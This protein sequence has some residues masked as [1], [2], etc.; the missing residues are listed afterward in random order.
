MPLPASQPYGLLAEFTTAAD[1]LHAAEKVRAAGFQRWD[2]FTPFP[3]HGMDRAMGLANSRVGYVAFCGGVAGFATG[4]VMIWFLNA[5]DYPILIGGKPMFSPFSAFPPAF[6]LTLLFS[7]F[8][9]V[10]GMLCF[11]RLPRLHHPLLKHRSFALASHD[12]YF[13]VIET[14]DPNYSEAETRQ[15]LAAAGSQRIELVEE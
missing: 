15:L 3:V 5:F 10:F 7:A 6:E 9:A 12:R 13:L 1:I 8:G 14:A 11:N 2:V 4:M